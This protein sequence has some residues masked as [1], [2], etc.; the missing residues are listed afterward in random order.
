LAFLLH[1]SQSGGTMD[2]HYQE[3]NESAPRGLLLIGFGVSLVAHAAGLK[4]SRK[5]AWQ[6]ILLGTLGLIVLNS[7]VAVFGESVKH[8][9]LYE[10][11]LGL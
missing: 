3:W 6:W 9:A 10:Q 2:Q 11:K 5:P 8:R 1:F 4:Q 7:G